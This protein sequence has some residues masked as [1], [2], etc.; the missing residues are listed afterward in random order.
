M[1]RLLS[2]WL[3]FL[4][5]FFLTYLGVSYSYSPKAFEYI[6]N[7]NNENEIV[8]ES[9]FE[10]CEIDKDMG[11][12]V[13][14]KGD[15]YGRYIDL[16]FEK[17]KNHNLLFLRVQG[18]VNKSTNW[19]NNYITYKVVPGENYDIKISVNDINKTMNLWLDGILV[20]SSKY[21]SGNLSNSNEV[22]YNG[23]N[24]DGTYI[25]NNNCS[26]NNIREKEN[27]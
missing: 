27:A 13:F 26:V 5:V 8:L 24:R 6:N 19:Y 21:Y 12:R 20:N 7:S 9:S 25:F 10:V 4:S 16:F 18:E 1:K 22:V 11:R 2:F 14:F 15:L 17:Y 23:Y 3:L